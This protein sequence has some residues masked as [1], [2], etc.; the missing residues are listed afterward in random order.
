MGVDLVRDAAG[1]QV[2][3]HGVQPAGH[4][5]AGAGQVPVASRPQLHHRR[6]ILDAD[7]LRRRC[8][9]RG[10]RDRQGVVRVVLVGRLRRQQPHA[11]REL[12]LHV[13]DSLAGS[14]E[15][16]GE[17]VAQARGVLDRPRAL[18]ELLRPLQQPLE[19]LGP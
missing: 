2:A 1:D 8:P 9:Q 14:D 11:R 18:R 17:Q 4:L 5:C 3:Q 7:L 15:L 19:L 6:V 12:R 16:L 10:D 13:Q